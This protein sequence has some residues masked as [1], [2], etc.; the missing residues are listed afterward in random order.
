MSMQELQ[1]RV[2]EEPRPKVQ[3]SF[4]GRIHS[5]FNLQGAENSISHLATHFE[6][7][8]GRGILL[9]ENAHGTP[10][11]AETIRR[12]T[13]AYGGLANVII[14]TD[15]QETLKVVPSVETVNSRRARIDEAGFDS[16]VTHTL[17]PSIFFAEYYLFKGI[18]SLRQTYQF[19]IEHESLTASTVNRVK[20][21]L[22]K[23]GLLSRQ[24]TEH[25]KH[26]EFDEAVDANKGKLETLKE[27]GELRDAAIADSMRRRIS[28]MLRSS[29]GGS[30]AMLFGSTH[31][32]ITERVK[33]KLGDSSQVGFNV[34]LGPAENLIRQVVYGKT[35][36]NEPVADIDH[37]HDI[38]I[39]FVSDAIQRHAIDTGRIAEYAR[40][41]ETL[42]LGVINSFVSNLSE[43]EMRGILRKDD[44]A[45]AEFVSKS[46]LSEQVKHILA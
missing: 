25:F 28:E 32:S 45:M 40:N 9:L 30:I 36:N 41:Y 20:S 2:D 10:T 5:P 21:L 13:S 31:S 46:S 3:V 1:K 12:K 22:S 8:T 16:V 35:V 42:N 14:A 4:S 11:M 18:D 39:N 44:K 19:D 26:G 29:R 15:L 34:Y 33:G 7:S 27:L 23:E 6:Q 24:E 17:L 38:A 37:L 43:D